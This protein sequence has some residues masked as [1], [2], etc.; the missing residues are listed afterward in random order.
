MCNGGARLSKSLPWWDPW[1]DSKSWLFWEKKNFKWIPLPHPHLVSSFPQWA[2]EAPGS[3][4]PTAGFSLPFRSQYKTPGWEGSP[5]VCARHLGQKTTDLVCWLHSTHQYLRWLY[6][7]SSF[8]GYGCHPPLGQ[9]VPRNQAPSVLFS[10]VFLTQRSV[11]ATRMCS[12]EC[13]RSEA[14]TLWSALDSIDPD[15][16]YRNSE[17]EWRF[18]I[19]QDSRP[20]LWI[21]TMIMK[22]S[23]LHSRFLFSS[24]N[25]AKEETGNS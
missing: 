4:F 22:T 3:Q 17:V 9:G 18:K 25:V 8:L 24:L 16:Q 13:L 12:T 5:K 1:W 23:N 19:N 11:P 21:S 15:P 20:C 6:E 2:K 7:N 10:A 14:H